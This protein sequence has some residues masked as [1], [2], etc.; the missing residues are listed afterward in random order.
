MARVIPECTAG[1]RA[2]SDRCAVPGCR[3]PGEFKAPLAPANFDGPGSWR[4]L[5]LDH[6]REHNA[7]YNFFDGMSADEITAAQSLYGGWER[8][9]RAVRRRRRRSAL[10]GA[11]SPIRSTPSAPRFRRRAANA[12]SRFNR[13]GARALSVLGLGEDADRNGG[14]QQLFEARPP[15]PS[16]QERRRPQPRRPARRSD[17]GL[18]V[19]QTPRAF[20]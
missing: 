8:A 6:V 10:R 19:A 4:F 14:A 9:S 13:S 1:S 12:P 11:T 7:N 16:R 17:R 18:S 3:E 2:R 5:C 20:A 15:L